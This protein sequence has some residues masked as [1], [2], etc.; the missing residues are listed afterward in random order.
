[1][2]ITIDGPAGSGKSTLSINLAKHLGFFCLNSGYL[3]RGLA[4]VLKTYYSY[5]D[6]MLS[7]PVDQDVQAC[8]QEN[9]LRYEYKNGLVYIFW[10]DVA[11]TQ[12]LKQVV[13][14][15]AAAIIAQND[16]VRKIIQRYEH[17]LVANKD[18]VIEGRSGGSAN[19]SHAQLKL[20]ITAS[21]QVRAQRMVH[22]QGMLKH[23]ITIK[24]ALELVLNRDQKDMERKHDPLV[25][26]KDAI[27]I[28]TSELTQKQVL[29]KIIDM[30]QK[31]IKL[32]K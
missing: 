13:I 3:Y 20:F 31:I 17:N 29:D 11:I 24:Q 21:V 1:M 27:I 28:D 15:Q 23:K 19:F 26:P 32:Q 22:D 5:S 8:L 2:I 7:N 14:G 9:S 4:Y 25:I 6:E 10:G 16:Q 12:F 18:A 30:V